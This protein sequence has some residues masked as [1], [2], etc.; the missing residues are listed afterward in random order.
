MYRGD[1]LFVDDR[2]TGH[3]PCR[4]DMT[5]DDMVL[6]ADGDE[7]T[8]LQRASASYICKA[9]LPKTR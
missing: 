5:M 2:L 6:G 8:C 7:N 3:L 9:S 4:E 1:L